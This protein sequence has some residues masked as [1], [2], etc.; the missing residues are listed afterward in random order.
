MH[1]QE[2]KHLNRSGGIKMQL[3]TRESGEEGS[4]KLFQDHIERL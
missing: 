1:A 3:N 2:Q 4:F